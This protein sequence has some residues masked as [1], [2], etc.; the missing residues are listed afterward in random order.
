MLLSATEGSLPIVC[1][2]IIEPP[3]LV[4]PYVLLVDPA[5]YLELVGLI[6]AYYILLSVLLLCYYLFHCLRNG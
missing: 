3:A 2:S 4:D 5:K 1:Y 6:A